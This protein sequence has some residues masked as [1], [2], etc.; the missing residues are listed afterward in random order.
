MKKYTRKEM[1]ACMEIRGF[2]PRTV[3]VYINHIYNLAAFFNK[4]PHTLSP[5]HIHK[6]QVYLVQEKQ[7]SWSFFNQAVCA[8]KFFLIMWLVMTG[9]SNTYPSGKNIK[10]CQLY[11]PVQK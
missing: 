4:A 8:M 7:V 9:R 10:N 1:K 5:D 2:S 6:Y 11:F 3:A